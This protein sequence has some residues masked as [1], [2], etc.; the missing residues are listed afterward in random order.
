MHITRKI[1]YID[2]RKINEEICLTKEEKKI[3]KL[4]QCNT[5]LNRDMLDKSDI[6]V[7]NVVLDYKDIYG[8][9]G[10]NFCNNMQKGRKLTYKKNC[11]V[12]FSNNI[13]YSNRN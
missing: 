2:K 13:Q 8:I 4:T 6:Y 7:K 5:F 1:Y 11:R 9:K 10:V 12:Q 3:Y